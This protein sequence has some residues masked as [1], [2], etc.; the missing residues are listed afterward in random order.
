MVEFYDR[1]DGTGANDAEAALAAVGALA[2]GLLAKLGIPE[3]VANDA[4]ITSDSVAGKR[5][6]TVARRIPAPPSAQASAHLSY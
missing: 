5:L 1:D 2:R 3:P 4:A 6:N